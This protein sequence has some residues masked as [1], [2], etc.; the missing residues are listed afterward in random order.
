MVRYGLLSADD[1][2]CIN[3]R[4]REHNRLGF[5]VQLCLL[6]YPGWPL[7]A[8]EK[9]PSNLLEF[10]AQQIDADP[11]EFGDYAAREPTR[12]EHQGILAREYGFHPYGS[13]YAGSLRAHLQTE[14]LSTDAAFTLV[15]SAM[16]W[17]RQRRVI[18]PALA[19]LESLVR[20][21]RG[22]IERQVYW[23]LANSLTT[24][25]R[26]NWLSCSTWGRRKGAC[27]AGCAGSHA[28]APPPACSISSDAYSGCGAQGCPM[29]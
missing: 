26:P 5:A 23:R 6:R 3:E 11:D 29:S 10:V 9:P 17:L 13:G 1:I 24:N 19:T 14:A 8:E 4:R 25:R 20:S 28:P 21:V 7:R 15:Q 2:R 16:E 18:L 27:W 12:H 22:T